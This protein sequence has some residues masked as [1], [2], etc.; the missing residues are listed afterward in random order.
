MVASLIVL[1][2]V[3]LGATTW[4]GVNTALRAGV[5]PRSDHGVDERGW[6]DGPG[7]FAPTGRSRTEP[8][9]PFGDQV[10]ARSDVLARGLPGS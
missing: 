1:V 6:L 2:L 7:V 9:D 10:V 4:V 3:V 5:P 8:T